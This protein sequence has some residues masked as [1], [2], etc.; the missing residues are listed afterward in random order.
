WLH[1]LVGMG[2][3]EYNMRY[4]EAPGTQ[5]WMPEWPRGDDAQQPR[6]FVT[7][8]EL[9][10]GLASAALLAGAIK[11]K[12]GMW[13]PEAVA[14]L[15]RPLQESF[16]PTVAEVNAQGG[17]NAPAEMPPTAGQA[18]ADKAVRNYLNK[19]AG[20]EG[21]PLKDVEIPFEE[22]TKKW[23]DA[24]DGLIKSRTADDTKGQEMNLRPGET[25]YIIAG[26]VTARLPYRAI[27]DYLS[28]VGDYLKQNVVPKKT[29]ANWILDGDAP[30]KVKDQF[31]IPRD[32]RQL[33]ERPIAEW[34]EGS[35]EAYEAWLSKVLKTPEWKAYKESDPLQQYDLVRAVKE[36]A[37]NDARVAKE[38]EKAAAASTKDMPV[39]KDFGDGMKW[40]ELKLPEKL[41]PEQA[42]GVRP[43]LPEE[44]PSFI[45]EGQMAKT[46]AKGEYTAIDAQGKPIKNSYG[47]N[48]ATG[49]TPEEAWLAG[50]LAEE[51]NQMG[52]CVGGYCEHVASGDTRILSLRDAKGRSHVTVEIRAE[53]KLGTNPEVIADLRNEFEGTDAARNG[54]PF[55]TWINQVYPNTNK[56]ADILQI[57]GKQNRGPNAEYLPYVQDLVK[58]GKWGEVG[59]LQNTGLHPHK[60]GMGS[61][62]PYVYEGGGPSPSQLNLKPGYYTKE[63]LHKAYTEAGAVLDSRHL[64]PE[65]QRGSA[66]PYQ[67]GVTA[68]A[69]GAAL[70]GAALDEDNRIRG[71][72]LGA[73][74]V[75]G[76]AA[77]RSGKGLD[78]AF[79]ALSTQ[80][81]NI[82]PALKLR[83]RNY[84]RNVMEKSARTLDAAY[85]FLNTLKKVEAGSELDLAL[86]NGD[87]AVVQKTLKAIPGGK[88]AYEQVRTVL[89][90]F[91]QT[92]K[93]LG[94]FKQG[95]TNYFPR[96]VTDV[97]GLKKALGQE[98]RTSLDEA[99]TIAEA[100]MIKERARGLTDVERSLIIDQSLQARPA[101]SQ[102]PGYARE[103]GVKVVTP[104]LRPFY[105]SPTDSLLRYLSASV[106]DIEMAAFFG[107]DLKTRKIGG[108]TVTDVDT[109]IGSIVERELTAKRITYE[110]A[111]NL[112][113]LLKSRFEGGEQTMAEPLQDVR[114][115]TNVALLGQ[116]GSAAT[117][118]G[119]SVMTIYHHGLMPTLG[120][121][122]EKLTGNAAVSVKDFGLVNHV[123]EELASSRATGKALQ[124]VFKANGFSLID[125]F[126]KGLN[127]NAGLIKNK[128]LAATEKGR[129][130]LAQKYATA[131]G[132]EFPQLVQ[133]LRE[134]KVTENVKSLLFS[135]LSDA[136]PIS[137][138]E[139]SP[140]YLDNPNGRVLFQM[141]TY[142]LKQMDIIRRDGYQEIAK[143]NYVRG[144]KNLV[145]LASAM[146]LSN[147]PGDVIKDWMSGRD[148]SL[149]KIDYMEA[150]L[151]NFGVSRYTLDKLGEGK[152]KDTAVGMVTP[153]AASL[154]DLLKMDKKAVK[155]IPLGGRIAYD[156]FLGGNEAIKDVEYK[157]ERRIERDR[158][159]SQ[160]PSIREER[161]RK[162]E[163][164]NQKKLETIR[165]R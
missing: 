12:G 71:A 157:R 52:H 160:Y 135:E 48:F 79:G 84:E 103:R 107:R 26:A 123:A 133:D 149:D 111:D 61:V 18:W 58:G 82:S 105:A 1:Q 31:P 99:L 47:E 11:G 16:R 65:G 19:H 21:D 36:T 164:K 162:Q 155:A 46:A 141:K 14:R 127:I 129:A 87:E 73:G 154:V 88:E 161:L 5:D 101:G 22:T 40:V 93:E 29:A 92:H 25:G 91:E 83:G 45:P 8:K 13:H 85:P 81:G 115:L 124:L 78:Y 62:A 43:S 69:G 100:K 140:A 37:A 165:N 56:P 89:T 136:Q 57:K 75:F 158:I 128:G 114:N 108:K 33:F 70:A 17:R 64:G 54:I 59:D 50:R 51:G 152:L 146:A 109:S 4:P 9:G 125:Q 53:R 35:P 27:T 32:L 144:A 116:F 86:L 38:M 76:V 3:P 163:E 23:G 142:M 110:Q 49:R 147:I 138:M 66:D 2:T 96:I 28:H 151:K 7:D 150:L 148:V 77:L 42:K 6:L 72:L 68:M 98:Q 121:I 112:R 106:Q 137:K 74:A 153:A 34:P 10:P 15:A 156:R 67:V 39:Y 94:R 139:M 120:A 102:L 126:A 134:G 80:L 55:D 117:Q 97:E 119:D 24:M 132:D 145:G 63:E 95:L 20:T 159:E 104:E 44:M 122:K 130:Q 41:T 90:A 131:F 113:K 30:K 60:I 143:G 118:I